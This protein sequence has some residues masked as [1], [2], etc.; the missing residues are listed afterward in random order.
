VWTVVLVQLTA[1]VSASKCLGQTLP[2]DGDCYDTEVGAWALSDA[3]VA[4][5]E[6]RELS[7]SESADS[8]EYSIPSRIR[9]TTQPHP[10]HQSLGFL[11]ETPSDVL[12]VP[13]SM[14]TWRQLGDSI[15]ITFSTGYI[16]TV[17]VLLPTS[18]GW[19][20]QQ[21][22]F[23]DATVGPRHKRTLRIVPTRCDSPPPVPVSLL[24]ALPRSVELADAR[25]LTLGDSLP[26]GL[27]RNDRRNPL[28]QGID[29]RTIGLFAG[30]D[31]VVVVFA[32]SGDVVGTIELKY[33]PDYSW[34]DLLSRIEAAWGSS[35]DRSPSGSAWW[36]SRT[37]QIMVFPR[38]SDWTH[39]VVADRRLRF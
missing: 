17:A 2:S 31:S 24:R 11:L 4:S 12:P 5:P 8:V 29:A 30:A 28:A 25:P 1:F 23:T 39:V 22:T 10:R 32:P 36:S 37:T 14:T 3:G 7:P 27:D 18:D 19:V 9:F 20:G 15:A 16:G 33:S 26:A 35:T 34:E 38:T 21:S 6:L 13:H